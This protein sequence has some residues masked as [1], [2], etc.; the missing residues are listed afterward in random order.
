[1]HNGRMALWSVPTEHSA[2]QNDRCSTTPSQNGTKK[3][4]LNFGPLPYNKRQP[5]T[6]PLSDDL[7][8]ATSARGKNS[9]ANVPNSVN[10]TCT[11]YSVPSTCS[12]DAR[13]RAHHPPNGQNAQLKRSMSATFTTTPDQ[14]QWSGILRQS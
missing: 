5:F 8:I 3:Y 9:Q 4:H 1:M 11:R 12:T 14:F 13:K 2:P 7:V 10:R 6:I